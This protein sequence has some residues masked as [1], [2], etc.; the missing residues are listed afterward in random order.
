M[1]KYLQTCSEEGDRGL[2]Q[3]STER[4]NIGSYKQEDSNAFFPYRGVHNFLS[5]LQAESFYVLS[6][7]N[8]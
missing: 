4:N 8:F 1:E 5:S 3:H 2:I 7:R 6:V